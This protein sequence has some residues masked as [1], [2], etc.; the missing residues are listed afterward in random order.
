MNLFLRRDAKL[1][2]RSGAPKKVKKKQFKFILCSNRRYDYDYD[3]YKEDDQDQ[4]LFKMEHGL[5]RHGG[6]GSL[7][8]EFSFLHPVMPF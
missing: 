8:V 1:P 3:D 2:P 5:D 7:K 6:C 4:E